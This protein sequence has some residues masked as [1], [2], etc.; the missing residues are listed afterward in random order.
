VAYLTDEIDEGATQRRMDEIISGGLHELDERAE[1][2][3][4]IDEE[5][6]QSQAKMEEEARAMDKRVAESHEKQ[7]A[8]AGK[9]DEE[10]TSQAQWQREARPTVLSFYGEDDTP[11]P[12]VGQPA[13]PATLPVPMPPP[14][15]EAPSSGSHLLSLGYEEAEPPAPA[16]Q[17]HGRHAARPKPPEDDD[18]LS[19]VNWMR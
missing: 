19:D 16:A 1:R 15:P 8:A 17:P 10:V 9:E 2:A 12:P 4:Q 18:D 14:M 13:L 5:F 7:N 3:A 11:T 6:R